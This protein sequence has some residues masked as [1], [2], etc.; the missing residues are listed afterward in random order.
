M[1]VEKYG[2]AI[3]KRKI[4][5][6]ITSARIQK[7]LTYLQNILAFLATNHHGSCVTHATRDFFTCYSGSY[8]SSMSWNFHDLQSFVDAKRKNGITKK[9]REKDLKYSRPDVFP[10]KNILQNSQEK[11]CATDSFYESFFLIKK[12]LRVLFFKE[13]LRWPLLEIKDLPKSI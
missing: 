11:S 13:H 2:W 8:Y 5:H 3:Q 7:C 9:S 1:L 6:F 10:L 12:F 4:L